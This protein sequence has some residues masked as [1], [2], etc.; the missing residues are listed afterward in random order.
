MNNTK[1]IVIMNAVLVAI[2]A[3]CFVFFVGRAKR[4]ED[5]K[6][7][8]KA[9][10]AAI[11]RHNFYL[12]FGLTK[13]MYSSYIKGF[14]I[15]GI[16]SEKDL[17][18]QAVAAFN[19]SVYVIVG[20]IVFGLALL[21][22]VIYTILLGFFGYVYMQRSLVKKSDKIVAD[23]YKEL[24]ST[25]SLFR[26]AYLSTNSVEKA[27]IKTE[28]PTRLKPIFEKMKSII[29]NQSEDELR[30]LIDSYPIT[31][32]GTL[33][34]TLY[35]NSIYGSQVS[36]DRG[37]SL[38]ST[39]LVIEQECDAE[40]RNC[41]HVKAAFFTMDIMALLGLVVWPAAEIFMK[42]QI[43]GIVVLIEGMYGEIVHL[44]IV[45]LT[46]FSYTFISNA[47]RLSVAS[48]SDVSALIVNISTLP[49]VS[50][51]VSNIAPKGINKQRKLRRKIASASSGKSIQ[52]IYTEKLIYFAG[53]FVISL[54]A[55][56]WAS[57]TVRDNFYNNY[58]SLSL[59][60]AQL[61][62]T[63]Q[64]QVVRFDNEFMKLDWDTYVETY[65]SDDETLS[66][67]IN[68][69][70]R[71]L[72]A[73]ELSEQVERIRTKYETWYN[74]TPKWWFPI[75]ALVIAIGATFMPEYSLSKRKK[76]ILAE[77]GNEVASL[78]ALMIVLSYSH[79]SC[80][81]ALRLLEMQSRVLKTPLRNALTIYKRNPYQAMDYLISCTDN[82]AF[83]HIINKLKSCIYDISIS[84]AFADMAT[85]RQQ[86]A[87]ISEIARQE[88]LDKK[89]NS[90]KLICMLPAGGALLG[91]F[92]A[93]VLILGLQQMSAVTAGLG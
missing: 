75:V 70:V 34:T 41:A 30:G 43:P 12:K 87:T 5:P 35:L 55:L 13:V 59:I 61:T 92:I 86:T 21:Q 88:A 49:G 65:Q 28:I 8:A 68:R 51:V 15:Y 29:T 19:M 89:K 60:P 56:F 72:G 16:T 46:I 27:F 77:T 2:T 82:E 26:Q 10:A 93:P 24:S 25:V 71:G 57:F 6:A 80:D 90:A 20:L 17:A 18:M 11:K 52:Y 36:E 45:I 84:E 63:Q 33:A 9:E 39:L 44:V 3:F 62:V 83:Q 74:A 69:M 54:L 64:E 14:S 50:T 73:M 78:Q 53:G 67:Y 32:V 31:V 37:D 22:N 79:V 66:S 38:A 85:Q 4:K 1:T 47:T 7:Q 76:D 40:Y 42:I 23:V 91:C 81:E 58:N 48:S